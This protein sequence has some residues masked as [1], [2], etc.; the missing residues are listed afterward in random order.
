MSG[1]IGKILSGFAI[2]WDAFVAMF[3]YY[4]LLTLLAVGGLDLADAF[5]VVAYGLPVASYI[6]FIAVRAL[7]RVQIDVLTPHS[8]LR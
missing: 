5:V 6:V 4:T 2:P 1:S 3:L 8:I 7:A